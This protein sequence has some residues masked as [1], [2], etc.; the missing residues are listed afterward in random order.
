M[1]LTT[2]PSLLVKGEHVTGDFQ[3]GSDELVAGS[4]LSGL[5]LH[6]S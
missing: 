1:E 5:D 6:L 4:R 3:K 2:A